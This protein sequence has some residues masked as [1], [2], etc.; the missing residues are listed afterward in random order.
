MIDVYQAGLEPSGYTSG[1]SSGNESNVVQDDHGAFFGE[2]SLLGGTRRQWT[3][4]SVSICDL[5]VLKRKD[6]EEVLA[7][8]PNF[9]DVVREHSN[10]RKW[11][12]ITK[13]GFHK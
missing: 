4:V 10:E 7:D 13:G 3:V 12:R 5:F 11:Q 6:F 1:Y 9:L 2:E 8:F